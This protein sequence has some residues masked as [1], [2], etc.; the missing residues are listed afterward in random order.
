MPIF[1][2]TDFTRISEIPKPSVNRILN[3]LA[4]NGV[5]QVLEHGKGRKPT[6]FLFTKLFDI[7]KY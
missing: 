2:T 1:N 7:I 3:V 4:D 6:V 5:L